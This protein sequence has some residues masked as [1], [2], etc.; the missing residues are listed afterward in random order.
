MNLPI[1]SKVILPPLAQE[2]LPE[3]NLIC[4][5]TPEKL[6]FDVN[7]LPSEG[8]GEMTQADPFP[9]IDYPGM[10]YICRKII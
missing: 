9:S 1:G 6:I 3:F 5:L 4:P 7:Y 2:I 10:G 8:K